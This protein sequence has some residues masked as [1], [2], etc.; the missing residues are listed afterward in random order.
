MYRRLQFAY[1][2]DTSL[3][4]PLGS[5]PTSVV[6]D[7][8]RSLA[9]RNLER[10]NQFKVASGQEAAAAMNVTAI[11]ISNIKIGQKQVPLASIAKGA[12]TNDCPLWAYILV[13]ATENASDLAPPV[14]GAPKISTP[15]LGP[16]GGRIVAETFLA[17]ANAY[18]RSFVSRERDWKPLGEKFG[19]RE[20]VMYA[21]G[22][23]SIQ[24]KPRL[25]VNADGDIV[26]PVA[27]MLAA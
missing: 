8:P 9:A 25:L 18:Q 5:L 12:F 27:A 20:L 21:L 11:N 13:E 26:N 19:L 3:V 24:I 23:E 14:I 16:V 1:K 15:Q 10:G 17:L 2:L 22:D 4:D 6:S 7:R